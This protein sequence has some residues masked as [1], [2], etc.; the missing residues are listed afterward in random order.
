MR[1]TALPALAVVVASHER[2]LRLRWL[3]NALAEQDLPPGWWELVVCFD[4]AGEQTARL[5]EHH[6]L[7]RAGVLRTVRLPAGTRN[8]ARQR[9]A[10]WRATTAPAVAFT[11]DDCRPPPGWLS[12]AL[13][14][15]RRHPG[16][17]VQGATRPD[18]AEAHL[19]AAPHARTQLVAPPVPWAQTCNV[20]Y[21]RAILE[22][23]GGFDEALTAGEDTELA[24][25][26]RA[27]HGAPYVGAPEVLTY[28][29]VEAGGLRA[30]LRT[31]PRW[32][33]L[34]GVVHRHPA[35]RR[36]L[37]LGL[38]WRRSHALLPLA[39]LGLV[40]VARGHGRDAVLVLPWALD[41][42]P[43]YGRGPR[44]VLRGA[45]E[46]PG[47]A[48]V[49]AAELATLVRGSIRWRTVVL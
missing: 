30:K 38:F 5:L 16:A 47:R 35:L 21:P 28:H 6:P 36:R 20:L 40:R 27:A 45:A 23:T 14:A 11:D 41:A 44:A 39:A 34:A 24:L 1:R 10:G 31:V 48:V 17:I 19:G 3:L 7:A 42:A 49:D 8:A 12:A 9:N 13:A 46:L 32:A 18:P 43:R 37:W 15:T 22:A 26:A 2:P 29:C 25:R 33:A 4:D